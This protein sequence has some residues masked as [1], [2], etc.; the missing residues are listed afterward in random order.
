MVSPGAHW[1]LQWGRQ[2]GAGMS[3]P[4]ELREDFS[5]APHWGPRAEAAGQGQRR[6]DP[7]RAWGRSWAF[8]SPH[9]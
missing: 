5:P 1:A 2:V 3:G 4:W 7:G 6:E 9:R 8:L